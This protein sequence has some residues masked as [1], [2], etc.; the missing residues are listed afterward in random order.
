MAFVILGPKGFNL[1]LYSSRLL[2]VCNKITNLRSTLFWQSLDLVPGFHL[3]GGG[4]RGS[5]PPWMVNF[6]P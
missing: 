4:S 5:F 1:Q 6:P 3:R 2:C